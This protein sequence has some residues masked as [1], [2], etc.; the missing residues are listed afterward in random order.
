[1]DWGYNM[2]I[3]TMNLMYYVALPEVF[4]EYGVNTQ[5]T[6]LESGK[7]FIHASQCGTMA[8]RYN[9]DTR[10]QGY[11][12]EGMAMYLEYVDGYEGVDETPKQK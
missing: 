9:G 4:S 1:M 6:R 11:D 5:G 12:A 2:H 3:E 7:V 10:I 8:I